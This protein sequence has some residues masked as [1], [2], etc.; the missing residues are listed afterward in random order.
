MSLL[1]LTAWDL[2]LAAGL[3]V[4][5]AAL[6]W[7]GQLG[8]GR[9]LL[10][11]GAR[12]VVQLLLIGLVLEALFA[13][14]ALHWVALLA[15]AML[16]IAGREVMARQQR[17]FLG[18]WGYGLGTL[19][20]SVSSFSITVLALLLLVQPEPWYRPQYAVPLL[21]MMLGNTMTG[22]AVAL[23]R[24][25]ESAWR[26]RSGIEGRLLLGQRWDQA[27][28]GLRREAMRAGMIP[29]INA[30]AAAGVVS[31]PGMMT[32]QILAGAPPVEAVKYQILIMFLITAGTGFG[33]LVAVRLGAR[34]LF[35]GRERLRLDRL[36]KP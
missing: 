33:T 4:V 13:F 34:R 8:V 27:V 6:S 19:A 23:D 5:L 20:M 7:Q 15:L 35:D 2:A 31:L 1:S 9:S 21:G 11:A 3:V 18:L 32:G 10:I 12:T 14:S 17:R 28:A 30:M 25:T 29:M 26:E 24:L 16:L 36:R 22:V